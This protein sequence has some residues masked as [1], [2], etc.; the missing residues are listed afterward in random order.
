MNNNSIVKLYTLIISIL[1]SSQ[2][3]SISD[4]YY[5]ILSSTNTPHVYE[6]KY[7]TGLDFPIG[8]VGGGTIRMN[9]KAERAWWQIFNNNEER[10][11][12]GRVP[13]S[14]FAIRTNTNGNTIVKA[15][16]TS[17]VGIFPAMNS[18]T[19]QGEFPFGWYTFNDSILP[20]QVKMEAF[21]PLIPMDLKN[22]SIPCAIYRISIKNTS[23]ENTSVSILATQQNAVGFDGYGIIGRGKY[24]TGYGSNVNSIISD[25][26]STSLQM[27]GNAGS[28]QLS[29]YETGMSTT[30]SWD[31]SASLFNDFSDDGLLTGLTTATS[32]ANGVTVDGALAKD[33]TLMPGQEK[34]ITFVLSW[35]IP[36]GFHGHKNVP[37]WNFRGQQY[38]NWWTNATDVD[39]YVK[40]NF[41][42]LYTES[43]LYHDVLYSSNI[44]RYIID[45][46]NSN[47]CVLKSP[48]VFWAKNGYFGLWES[49][50]YEELW[51]GNA[52]HVYQYAQGISW[53]FPEL[54]RRIMVQNLNTE[55]TDGLLP[56]R[57]GEM[58]K[59]LDG[60]LGTILGIY[61][62]YLLTDDNAWLYT[63]W[64]KTQKA[65]DYIISA[66]DNNKDGIFTGTYDNTLDCL[67]S[68]TNPVIGSMYVAALKATAK[69]AE[70]MND[71]TSRDLYNSIAVTAKS[72]LSV[73][74][75]DDNLKYF[76]EKSENVSGNFEFGNGS[77]ISMFDGQWWS[78]M[79]NLGQIFPTNK[80]NIALSQIYNNN[81]VTDSI[82]AYVTTFRDFLGTGDDGWIMN[83]FPES[84]PAKPVNYHSE[85]MSGFEY[86]FASTLIQSGMLNEGLDVVNKIARRY[87]GRLRAGDETTAYNNATVFGAG[88]PFGED[89]CGD[90]YGRP[91]SSWSVLTSLQGYYY[92]GPTKIIKFEPK[93]KQDDHKSFFS[94]ST[95]WGM[96]TQ[97]QSATNQV[98]KIELKYGSTRIRTIV[99]AIPKN[100]TAQHIVAS[101]NGTA[102]P[103][104]SI[105][106]YGNT[107]TIILTNSWEVNAG[108]NI[109]VSFDL[110]SPLQSSL[111]SNF[112]DGTLTGWTPVTGSWSNVN[113]SIQGSSSGS[114][115]L[116]KD[117]LT[118]ENFSYEADIKMTTNSSSSA[119][120]FGGNED[121]T[122]NYY[123][124][125]D[126]EN[127]EIKLYKNTPDQ[128]LGSSSY[129]LAS[130]TWYHLKIVT[131]SQN[132]KVYFNNETSPI[133]DY[134]SNSSF[135]GKF[136][137]DVYK[138][139]AQ[140]DNVKILEDGVSTLNDNALLSDLQV[141]GSTIQGFSLDKIVYNV[142][143]PA[144]TELFPVVTAALSD[145]ENASFLITQATGIPGSANIIVTAQDGITSK[146][147]IIN[148]KYDKELTLQFQPFTENFDSGDIAGWTKIIGTWTN[149]GGALQGQDTG[150]GQIMK[151]D[152][153]GNNFSY[154][155]DIKLTTNNACG[156]LTFRGN[157][158]GGITYLVAL[159]G[160]SSCIKLYK[161][162]YLSLT[163]VP[164]TFNINTWYHLKIIAD[165]K[166]IKVYFENNPIP[167]I[168]F[169]DAS[170]TKGKFG[171]TVWASTAIF[172]NIKASPL[173]SGTSGIEKSMPNT[174]GWYL[175]NNML[176]FYKIPT[177]NIEIFSLTGV[178]I[179]EYKPCSQINLKYKSGIYIVK[180]DNMV[181]KI[182]VI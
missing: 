130:S 3:Y 64:T 20:V 157:D 8:A 11:G 54:S 57:D 161:F 180:A 25:A 84:F 166:N 134:N 182:I 91:L 47:L 46:I 77:N 105:E 116:S 147:Y 5:D 141:N 152:I 101:L 80:T 38:E 150:N 154:E 40:T 172:D 88:S 13:N 89:E 83:K 118:G 7:L 123:I 140:F 49:T 143:I 119:L 50:S 39:T 122:N 30:A 44:P 48:T 36:D 28:L 165:T 53:I 173:A 129:P 160:G 100:K 56:S 26:T 58:L 104:S 79:L 73:Q 78:N 63:V 69:M 24:F 4:N 33:F 181:A 68:G 153:I 45:R 35:Y 102:L 175:K 62:D 128:I 59:T 155:A 108:S 107:L 29:A 168:D 111:E 137:L 149:T 114:I 164:Y 158:D 6:G 133:I 148:F 65:M 74:L 14:F 19:F 176:K 127:S 61:R 12:S 66:Y 10:V 110:R 99:L 115:M 76:I 51:F 86:A 169:N 124:A 55:T 82:G 151:N 112:I 135:A 75:W 93:W 23:A 92:D 21:N 120:T 96:F 131:N 126:S 136:G 106:Q 17:S 67:T 72:N 98:S 167:V 90:F 81:K 97:T 71:F 15:L 146:N 117:N 162:P 171:L 177:S 156:V 178:K 18:L 142:V 43:K 170:Y 60:H 174:S 27:T 94:T 31:N 32:S 16:Q 1:I 113:G 87:D 163:T 103:F 109:A 85:V 144:G 159:D 132:I 179:D 95:S 52:K 37:K 121:C 2:A 139:T 70:R 145:S 42:K 41:D 34:I 9:G 125:L 22:S 138:G